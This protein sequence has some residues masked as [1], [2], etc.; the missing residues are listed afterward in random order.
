[1]SLPLTP[2][3]TVGPYL[4]L[5]LPWPDGPDVVPDGTPGAVLIG[6]TVFDGAG[7]LVPDALVETWQADPDGRF[8]H[9]DDPRGAAKSS[10]EGFRG[11]GRCPTDD[12]GRWWIR[13]VLPGAL[14]VEA[15]QGADAR[16]AEAPRGADARPA[17]AP[18]VNVSVFARGL[19]DRVV[20]RIYFPEHA[21]AHT[22]DPLLTAVPADRRN[23]LVAVA[24]GPGRYRFDIR[25]RGEGETVFLTL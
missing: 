20:T 8:D 13:T 5:G 12:E 17:E 4:A 19:L 25:L 22:T 21:A 6:G 16:S 1:M 15:P 10:V 14:P 3:Q 2:T 11:F 7:A 24:D 9:P 23:T 18:H